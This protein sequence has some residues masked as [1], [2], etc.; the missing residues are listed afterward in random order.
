ML[1]AKRTGDG[2]FIVRFEDLDVVQASRELAAGQ[3]RDLRAIG[4]DSDEDP[5]FQSERFA[6]YN[7][8]IDELIARGLTYPCF[9]TRR[10]ISEAASAPNGGPQF[11]PGTCRSLSVRERASRSADRPS[12]VRLDMSAAGFP[13]GTSIA[14]DDRVA[15]RHEALVNDVVLRRNDGVPSYNL[16]VVVDDALQGVTEVVRGDDLLDVTPTQ[17]ALHRVLGLETP[18]YAHVPLMNDEQGERMEKRRGGGTLEDQAKIGMAPDEVR[19]MLEEQVRSFL[20]L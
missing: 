3:M 18:E 6:I 17:I 9:C 14:F 11:Y 1:S 5:I 10:E 16:A 2:A 15:G 20:S 4:V 12:A 8:K 7:G 13:T 19:E